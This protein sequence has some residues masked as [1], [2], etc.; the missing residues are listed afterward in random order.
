MKQRLRQWTHL[1]NRGLNLWS[2]LFAFFI[3]GA[4]LVGVNTVLMFRFAKGNMSELCHVAGEA[5]DSGGPG[6]L[7]I[8]MRGAAAGHGVRVHLI[9]AQG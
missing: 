7:R 9:G 8:V 2:V 4:A 1:L 5:Y 6:S 3:L